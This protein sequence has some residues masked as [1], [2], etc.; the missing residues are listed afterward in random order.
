MSSESTDIAPYAIPPTLRAGSIHSQ[1]VVIVYEGVNYCN[2]TSREKIA[3][4]LDNYLPDAGFCIDGNLVTYCGDIP[5]FQG[6]A[7][8]QQAFDERSVILHAQSQ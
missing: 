5:D 2:M 4:I 1:P 7:F 8:T 3:A 6:L